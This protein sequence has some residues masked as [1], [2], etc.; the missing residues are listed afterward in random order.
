MCF[1]ICILALFIIIL[2]E[3]L[4]Y[5]IDS[6]V[7][8]YVAAVLEYISADILKVII[9]TFFFAFNIPFNSVIFIVKCVLA[10]WE[11]CEKYPPCGNILPGHQGGNVC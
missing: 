8:L 9:N 2:Q 7:S 10:C 1:E 6:Q 4:Q 11:L 5:K 3:V